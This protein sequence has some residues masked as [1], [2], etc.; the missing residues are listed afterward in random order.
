MFKVGSHDPFRHLKHKLWLNERPR[1]KLVDWLPTTK[2][3]ESTRFPCVQVVCNT[4][5]ESCQRGLQLWFRRRPDR[6]SAREV[7][8]PQN[9]KNSNLGNFRIPIWE[10]QIKSH[11]DASLAERCRVYYMGEGGGF[12]RVQ[13][14]VSFV[15]PRSLVVHLS[16]KSAPTL[17]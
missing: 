13:A 12:P 2:S 9:R 16:T 14:V 6:R 3:L 8:A 17:C 11:L 15:S 7:I 4:P 10:S 5:L 1:I